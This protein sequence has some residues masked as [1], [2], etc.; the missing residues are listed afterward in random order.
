MKCSG[1]SYVSVG[2]S[3]ALQE[4]LKSIRNKPSCGVIPKDK[5]D[6]EYGVTSCE[7]KHGFVCETGSKTDV[8]FKAGVW[9]QSLVCGFP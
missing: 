4:S 5:G 8:T 3:T 1:V 6:A 2:V 7:E 9:G